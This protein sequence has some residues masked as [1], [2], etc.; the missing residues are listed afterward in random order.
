MLGM[1]TTEDA[2]TTG[3]KEIAEAL[4][5]GIREGSLVMVEGEA[6]TGKSVICQY[7]TSGILR[8]RQTSVAYFTKE[9][10][11]EGLVRQMESISLD[12]SNYVKT[13]QFRVYPLYEGD[14]ITNS[15][16]FL[17]QLLNNIARLP[18]RFQLIIVDAVTPLI[19]RVNLDAKVDFI[20][21]CKEMGKQDRSIVMVIDRHIYEGRSLTRVFEMSDYYLQLQSHDA[22]L[23]PGQID[24]RVIKVLNVTKMAGAERASQGGIRFEIK[25]GAGIQILPFLKVK[26]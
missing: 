8:S 20:E 1:T 24:D 11:P 26:I 19:T 21:V 12:I 22:I 23:E 10:T 3:M 9:Y 5:G 4:G 14:V 2:T 6:K 18:K 7:I 25:P 16:E 13:D 15:K 17:Q